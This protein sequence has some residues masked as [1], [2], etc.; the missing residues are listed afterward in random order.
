MDLSPEAC[1]LAV[2]LAVV[3]V[4]WVTEILP[5]PVTALAGAAACVLA[6]V[7]PMREVFR[8][9]ADPLIFLFIGSFMLAEAIR[10][11]R[12]DRRLAFAVLA[13]PAVGEHPGRVLAAVAAVSATI[14]AF[15][16]NTATTAMMTTIAVGI[17]AAVEDAGSA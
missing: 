12:L 8:P 13:L 3:V 16:S 1:S 9:F 7:A 10:V 4:A 17:L 5:L 14:S 2:I 15:I 6:G 11:H